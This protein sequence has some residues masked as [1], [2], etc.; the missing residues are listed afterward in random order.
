MNIFWILT[1]IT[2]VIVVIL[3]FFSFFFPTRKVQLIMKAV[4]DF[5]GSTNLLLAFFATNDNN[6]VV[7]IVISYLGVVRDVLY[8][9]R[10]KWKI[11][12]NWALPICFC[13]LYITAGIFT[14][15]SS[16]S[17][18]PIMGSF[19][20]SIG[21]YLKNV[22]HTKLLS[23]L[24]LAIYITYYAICIPTSSVLTIFSLVAASVSFV[25]CLIGLAILYKKE[26]QKDKE[27][28]VFDDNGN[29]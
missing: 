7:G 3:S 2:G 22:K 15:K 29:N 24:N 25:G 14:Y 5:A 16:I 27:T 4:N 19:I 1:Y 20:S 9:F 10:G 18:L 21:L 26:K 28:V 6:L 12:N 23:L 8:L 13:V 11:L 17:L